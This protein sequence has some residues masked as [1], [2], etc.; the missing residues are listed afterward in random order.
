MSTTISLRYAF[1]QRLRVPAPA[2]FA[3]CTDFR[4][5]D[6]RLFGDRRVRTVEPIG[7]DA[8]V[9]TDTTYPAGRRQRIRRLVRIFPERRAWTNTHLDGPFRHSQFWYRIVPE[10]AGRCRLEFEGLKLETHRRPV[11]PRDVARLTAENR[12]S[13]AGAWRDHFAPALESEW[14]RRRSSAH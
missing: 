3:W 5:S 9:M 14:G 10:G 7:P 6:A 8:L 11:S 2:A 12:R 4:A 1:R 13:D